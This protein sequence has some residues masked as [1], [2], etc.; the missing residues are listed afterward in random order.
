MSFFY[1]STSHGV[2][3][4]Y[5]WRSSTWRVFCFAHRYRSDVAG[6]LKRWVYIRTNMVTYR[7]HGGG[8]YCVGA[9]CEPRCG[10]QPTRRARRQCC[11]PPLTL[12]V[13]TPPLPNPP[14]PFLSPDACEICSQDAALHVERLCSPVRPDLFMSMNR[15][16]IKNLSIG[17]YDGCKVAVEL[18]RELARL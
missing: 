11:K 15:Q 10:F 4:W 3:R 6:P 2:P 17:V 1:Y 7:Y 13:I 12:S 14:F 5:G 16:I 8:E 18:A 9:M